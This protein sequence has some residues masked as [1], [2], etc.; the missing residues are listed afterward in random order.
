MLRDILVDLGKKMERYYERT[1]AENMYCLAT[2]M[3]PFPRSLTGQGVRDTLSLIKRTIPFLNIL[4]V[5]SGTPAFDWVVPLEWNP[6]EAYIITPDGRKICN[7]K[8]NNL[9]LVG[10]S[11][12]VDCEISLKDLDRHLYSLPEQPHAIPYVTSYYHRNWGFCISETERRLLVDGFYKVH[13]DAEFVDGNL[14]YGEIIIPGNT[15]EE[16]FLSTYI[17][18]PSMANNEI[19]GPVVLTFLLDYLSKLASRRYTYRA[20][21][22]PETIGSI[23]YLSKNLNVMKERVKAGF[24]ITCVGD[25]RAYSYLPSRA[26]NTLSDMVAKHVLEHTDP[27]FIVYDWKERG[28]DE[29]QYCAPGVD[30]PIASMMRSKYKCYPEYHTS[31]DNLGDVVTKDG[32]F[33]G[34]LM[35]KR[36]L[37]AL[38][39]NRIIRSKILCEPQMSRRNLYP[40]ISSVKKDTYSKN[41][42]NILTCADGKKS[43]I[44]IADFCGLSIWELLP[45][46]DRLMKESI[47][48][49]V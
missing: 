36:A 12:P 6:V 3:F 19:S 11:E 41:I 29:R 15:D 17:C 24:N 28:S 25:N 20:V 21:F 37:D 27:N 5:P 4:E 40:H 1:T 35:Y 46:V 45:F 7:F 32:L 33:G 31:L 42:M 38:E 48:D 8:E 39:C 23:V 43:L 34:Y 26:G 16:V 10:Y 13:I 22:I 49:Y 30:L 18:H 14:T 9:H 47:I 2:E 44:E